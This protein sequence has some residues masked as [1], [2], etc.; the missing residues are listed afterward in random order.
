MTK[1]DRIEYNPQVCNGKPVTKGTPIPV[2]V[3][4]DQIAQDESWEDLLK[5]YPELENE[6]IRSIENMRLVYL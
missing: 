1:L 4:L 6:D 3:I 5:G 2:S